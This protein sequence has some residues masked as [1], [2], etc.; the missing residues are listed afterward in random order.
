MESRVSL[1]LSRPS[2][3]TALSVCLSVCLAGCHP[4]KRS[5]HCV[6]IAGSEACLLG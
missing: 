6:A 4:G 5:N 3:L 1:H 2:L